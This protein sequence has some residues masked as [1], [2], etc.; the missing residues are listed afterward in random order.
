MA[1]EG[2]FDGEFVEAV[3]DAAVEFAADSPAAAGLGLDADAHDPRHVDEFFHAHHL[4]RFEQDAGPFRLGAHRVRHAGQHFANGVR[5]LVEADAD[6]DEGVAVVAGLVGD[7]GDGGE[8]D[9]VDGAVD[10]AEAD[11]ADGEGFDSAAEA[12]EGDD[13]ADLHGVLEEEEKA[14][15][16][17]LDE[18][19]RAKADGDADNAGAGEE[20][21]DV[22]ADLAERHQDDDQE[23]G[24]QQHGAEHG[25]QGAE[26][27]GAGELGLFGEP[28]QVQFEPGIRTFPHAHGEQD[29]DADEGEGGYGAAA[30]ARVFE[31]ADDAEAP[32]FEEGEEAEEGDQPHEDGSGEG[33]V[34]GEPRFERW[35]AAWL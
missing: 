14:G 12:G 27:A 21:S 32:G 28:G 9:D 2:A 18:F 8:W 4:Q 13:V 19:L 20:R 17:V 24:D 16:E 22:H 7:G 6:V 29:G 3:L 31:P 1:G 23:D 34:E 15:N 30:K 5:L 26:A 25:Q 11:S 10:G 33:V 35:V